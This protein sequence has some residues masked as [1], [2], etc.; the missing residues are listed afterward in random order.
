M[1]AGSLVAT[2]LPASMRTEAGR[3]GLPRLVVTSAAATAEIYLQGAHVT[4]WVPAGGEPV[5]WMSEKSAFAPGA[6]LRGG[7]PVC[8]P[9]FGPH[10]SGDA[11]LHGFARTAD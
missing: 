11:P 3:G 4:S 2:S 8:F 10:P 6:P 1:P 9:W 5:I 7:V